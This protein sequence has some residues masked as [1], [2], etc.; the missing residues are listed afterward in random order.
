MSSFPAIFN[1]PITLDIM[2]DPVK[3]PDGH[4]YE[5]SAIVEALTRQGISPLTRQVMTLSNLTYLNYCTIG[6]VENRE[7]V[8]S[9]I[10]TPKKR[11]WD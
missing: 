4:T 11:D 7:D 8:K 6:N 3:A 2:Q 5:R 9:K 10:T 1:C